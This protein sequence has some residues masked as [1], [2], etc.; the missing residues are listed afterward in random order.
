ML[1]VGKS[2]KWKNVALVWLFNYKLFALWVAYRCIFVCV[3]RGWSWIFANKLVNR[4]SKDGFVI[5]PKGSLMIWTFFQNHKD[6]K[7]SGVERKL[8]NPIIY[9]I[10][11]PTICL[12]NSHSIPIQVL[13]VKR[14]SWNSL[15]I[16]SRWLMF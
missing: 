6:V 7:I 8:C 4:N 1:A 14:N 5:P 11:L 13:W 2:C 3:Y 9:S 16:C 10:I 12:T 15:C